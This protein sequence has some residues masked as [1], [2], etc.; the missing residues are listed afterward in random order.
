MSATAPP[1]LSRGEP[2]R[3]AGTLGDLRRRR[4]F[5]GIPLLALLAFEFLLGMALNLYV[6]LPGGSPLA[7]LE[8]NPLLIGHIL[9]G[10]LLLG[11]TAQ[12]LNLGLK[13]HDRGAQVAGAIGLPSVVVAVLAGMD[14][15]FGGQS[16]AASYVMSVGFTGALACAALLLVPNEPGGS[17]RRQ[18]FGSERAGD[19]NGR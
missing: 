3:P 16:T 14:F 15:T 11:I 7:I 8:S 19:S 17:E 2:S 1:P 12:A 18:D 6:T 13:L 9:V 4:R 5:L 10:I